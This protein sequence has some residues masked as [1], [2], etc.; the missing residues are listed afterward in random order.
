MKLGTPH[1]RG[2]ETGQRRIVLAVAVSAVMLLTLDASFNFVLNDIVRDLNATSFQ[3]SVLRQIPSVAALL[4]VFLAG[5]LGV[6]LGERRVMTA[7]AA[8]YTVGSLMVAVSPVIA[9]VTLGVLLAD[10]GR[11]VLVVVGLAL[12]SSE[13]TDKNGR[14]T[15][16]A[17]FTAA[18]PITFLLMPL[19]A[20]ALVEY[21]NWR[22]VAV[23][24]AL[25]GVVG[26]IALLRLLPHGRP[27]SRAAGEMVTPAL[28]GLVLVAIVQV[29]TVLPSQGL[30]ARV[31]FTIALG[32]A[33]TVALAVALR[34]LRRPTFSL[35][36]LR[37]GGL[38][39]LLV[40]LVLTMFANLWFYMTMGLQYIFGLDALGAAVVTV[41]A[42]ML[43]I[44]GSGL[45]G[46]FIKRRGVAVSGTVL[47][48]VVALALFAT[49]LI[50]LDTPIWVSVLM[51]SVY[52]AAAVGASVTLTNAVMDLAPKGEEG[53]FSSYR[54]AALNLGS[55]VGVAGM[56]T[57]VFLAASGFLQQQSVAA[58]L[59][60]DTSSQIATELRQGTTP[61]DA[62]TLYAVPVEEVDQITEI[63]TQ[64]FVEGLHAHGVVGGSVTLVA[65]GVFFVVRRKQERR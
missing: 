28:A 30:T 53:I 27:A 47:L 55:A 46:A 6:R 44:V 1:A 23:V 52:S 34:R 12:I 13:V 42:Q 3:T 39:L 18:L 17:A 38:V 35:T 29:I 49:A 40:V 59:D 57:I 14:A 7:C 5:T 4:V 22:W 36:P 10:I 9:T 8:L 51:L 48:V 64:A 33:A 41:P 56:T 11:S 50:E 61:E 45:A 19:V 31:W 54:G 65:A 24:W 21:A 60:P 58:G 43:S 62:A 15:A 2:L 20:G 37:G 26:L 63:Q 16:F 32:T 25:S